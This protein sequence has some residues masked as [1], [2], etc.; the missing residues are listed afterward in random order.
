MP[1]RLIIDGNA[2]YE[3]DEDCTKYQRGRK[4]PM[5]NLQ[6]NHM[7]CSQGSERKKNRAKPSGDGGKKPVKE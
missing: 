3:I 1:G 5:Q 6:N 4:M 7:V 2:V